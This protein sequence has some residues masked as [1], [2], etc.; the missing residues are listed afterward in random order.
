[1]RREEKRGRQ[2]NKESKKMSARG[3]RKRRRKSRRRKGCCEARDARAL[4]LV[5]GEAKGGRVWGRNTR[6]ADPAPVW[7]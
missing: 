4:N 6:T 7:E 3:W 1:M 2:A 5:E